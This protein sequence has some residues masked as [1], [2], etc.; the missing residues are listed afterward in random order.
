MIRTTLV[1]FVLLTA[2]V[3]TAAQERP[4]VA[5]IG[6]GIVAGTLG[7]ALGARGYTVIYG[8]R[9]PDR[10]SVRDLVAQTG[11]N[12]SAAAQPAAAAKADIVILTVPVRFIPEVSASLGGLT[13]KIIVDIAATPRRIAADGYLELTGDS[14]Y[15]ERLQKW[16]PQAKVVRMFIPLAIYFVDPIASGTPPTVPI[17]GNDPRAK[18]VVA[19]MI[20]D[21]GLDPWDAGPLRYAHALDVLGMLYLVPLQQGRTEGVELKLLRSNI[22]TCLVDPRDVFEFGTPYDK[23]NLAQ[24]PQPQSPTVPCEVWRAKFYGR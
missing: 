9:E 14:T 19:K 21:V 20:F 3:Y 10:E 22:F 15:A 8:S 18:E 16:H 24:F 11:S 12:A 7:P 2:P 13:G 1:A 17:V 5:I 6:T 4:S 23:Q